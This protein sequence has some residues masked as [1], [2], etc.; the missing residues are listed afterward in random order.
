MACCL[1]QRSHR[2][3]T[4]GNAPVSPKIRS[5][6]LDRLA[7]IDVRQSTPL[8]VRQHAGSAARQSDLAALAS[9]LGWPT[10]HVQVIDQ[11]QG[12]AGPPRRAA[13]ASSTSSLRSAWD[14]PEPYSAWRPR[15]WHAPAVTGLVSSRS[16]LTNTLVIDE[17]GVHDSTV[18]SDRLLLGF[19]NRDGNSNGSCSARMT[20]GR[21]PVH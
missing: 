7:L 16:A 19:L 5:D 20:C 9:E 2:S 6:H 8:P 3:P 21:S 10:E 17:D 15:A 1:S 4:D 13:T 11:D 12:D 14:G 18:Y